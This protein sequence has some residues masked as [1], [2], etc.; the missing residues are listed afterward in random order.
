MQRNDKRERQRE[1]VHKA[2]ESPFTTVAKRR[3]LAAFRHRWSGPYVV[4]V[5]NAY[6]GA[7][8]WG[9]Y[10]KRLTAREGWSVARLARQAG[11]NRSTIFGWIKDGGQSLTV[12]SVLAVAE[13]G[14]D[15]PVDAL[16]AAG[17]VLSARRQATDTDVELAIIASSGLPRDMQENLLARTLERRRRE[18]ETRLADLRADIRLLG[19]EVSDGE[20]A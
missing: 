13:G 9:R 5:G 10:V 8:D 6:E 3:R 12:A 11:L 1:L 16:L 15:S 14:E 20:V 7:D 19:G 18:E 4:Y 17:N 2:P